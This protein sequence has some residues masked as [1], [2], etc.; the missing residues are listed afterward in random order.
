MPATIQPLEV[1]W[2]VVT[3]IGVIIAAVNWWDAQ[4][5]L[6]ALRASGHNGVLMI[7]ALGARSD[8][9]MIFVALFCDSL[10][11][12]LALFSLPGRDPEGGPS[13]ASMWAPWLAIIGALALI[14]LSF[15]QRRRRQSI[16]AALLL[17]SHDPESSVS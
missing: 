5:D 11:G 12:I 2:T 1:P 17:K 3:L 15:S 4:G 6:D 9:Q 14:Y 10:L 7:T 16:R 13:I 8:Q